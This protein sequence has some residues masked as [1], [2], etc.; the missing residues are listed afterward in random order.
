MTF[1]IGFRCCDGVVLCA[2]SLE[3]DR[4]TKRYVNK[5]ESYT[6][7]D[8]WGA[9]IACS[10][11]GDVIRKF[12]DKLKGVLG[13]EKYDRDKLESK[14][15]KT[16]EILNKRYGHD[17][18][19]LIALWA[20]TEFEAQLYR[21]YVGRHCLSPQTE[22]AC[23]G[24]DT[25][26]ANFI[27]STVYNPLMLVDEAAKLA[28]WI[29]ALQREHADGV[30]GPINLSVY[31]KGEPCWRHAP[32]EFVAELEAE[33]PIGDAQWVI[34]NHWRKAHPSIYKPIFPKSRRSVSQTSGQVP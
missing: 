2:D 12:W 14:I 1:V 3:G 5:I 33:M 15:E 32:S 24:M 28:V 11:G 19:V 13:N 17:I 23:V 20:K 27:A 21:T 8:E 7:G 16:V 31:R 26:L 30:D 25:T 6:V 10:G 4:Y 22:Y 29:T 18:E 9:A 34:W